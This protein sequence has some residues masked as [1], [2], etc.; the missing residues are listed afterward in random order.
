MLAGFGTVCAFE[1]HDGAR[2]FANAKGVATVRDGLLPDGIPFD[3][4]FDLVCAFDVVEHVEDDLGALRALGAK[5]APGGR[6]L[7][8]VPA[9]P[10]L[11]SEHDERNHHF[12]RYTRETLAETI[13]AA[14]L[15]ME[16]L[17]AFNSRLFPLISTVRFVQ[18]ALKMGAKAEESMPSPRVNALLEKIFASEASRVARNGYANGVSLLAVASAGS[19]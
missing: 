15:K 12:R 3:Q 19:S 13:E 4:L 10:W 8:T 17:T 14:G 11:W 18:N 7:L 5:L 16:K 6:L 1:P 2:A 9:N